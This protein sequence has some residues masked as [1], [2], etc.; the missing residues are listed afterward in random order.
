M[1]KSLVAL[2]LGLALAVDGSMGPA[3]A[4]G[5]YTGTLAE[6][7]AGDD[8]Y[9]TRGWITLPTGMNTPACA[10]AIYF[11]LDLTDPIAKFHFSAA[12]AAIAVGKTVTLYGAGTPCD[13][14]GYERLRGIVVR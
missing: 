5:A 9:P 10:S 2:F 13:G 4:A 3:I 12:L 11:V 7:W 8:T 1:R 14:S 6:V